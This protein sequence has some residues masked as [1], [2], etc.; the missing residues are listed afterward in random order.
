M[1]KYQQAKTFE[2]LLQIKYGARGTK[3]REE[4]EAKAKIFLLRETGKKSK[5]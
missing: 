1:N 2:E 4:F 5:K 3:K